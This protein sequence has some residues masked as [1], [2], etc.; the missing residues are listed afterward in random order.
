MKTNSKANNSGNH[1]IALVLQGGGALG[2]YQAGV[3]QALHEHE[4]TPDWIVGTS[5]GAVNAAVIAGNRRDN[6]L[7]RLQQFWDRISF[8]DLIDMRKVPDPARQFNI[9]LSTANAVWQGVPGFFAPRFPSLFA[10]GLPVS[11]ETASFYDT[12]GLANT[13]RDL[14]NFD[15]L[16]APGGIRMTMNA[17]QVTAGK[18]VSFDNRSSKLGIEHVMACGAL[19]WATAA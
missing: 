15:Y 13:L 11:P 18:L 3:Y 6:R 7:E 5:I 9:R 2:A 12:S 1:R 17:M 8:D 10:A 4:L 14:V 19:C 16:N